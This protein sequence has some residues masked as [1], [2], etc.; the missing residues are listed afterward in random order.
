MDQ[1]YRKRPHLLCFIVAVCL[2]ST[3]AIPVI[4]QQATVFPFMRSSISAR[5]A[6]LGGATVAMTDDLSMVVLNPA[7][8]SSIREQQVSGTFIKHVLDI[9]SGVATFAD[10]LSDNSSF[11]VT[12][13]YSSY[14]A[15][16]RTDVNGQNI[17][18]FTA[19][20]VCL[21]GSFAKEIDTLISWGGT[22]KILYGAI[23]QQ[24]SIAVAVDAG[25]L[26]RIPKSR[27]N[28]GLS[29]LNAGTQ[30]TTYAGSTNKLPLDVRLGVN[31]RLKGLP[32]LVNF[33][34]GQLADEVPTFFDRFLNFSVGGELSI[35]KYV[36]AR[37]GYDNATRNLS[38][39]NVS[40]QLSGVGGGIGVVLETMQF[41]YA[42]N[43]MGSSALLHRLTVGLHL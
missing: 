43:S 6:A 31:H 24:N 20:D 21:A 8:L 25:M 27:T 14:G 40:T 15:F 35:G 33:A 38:G 39:V 7:G 3:F 4:A 11:A 13:I 16:E 37:L 9:N 34:L 1:T 41:D 22:V 42:I 18:S 2:C 5:A 32:L 29:I 23:D 17:G 26:I 28:L 10:T 30:L 36:K 12:A 19:N